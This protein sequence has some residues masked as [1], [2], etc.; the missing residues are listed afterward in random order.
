[1]PAVIPEDPP[2]LG[3]CLLT[4]PE[5]LSFLNNK[6]KRVFVHEERVTEMCAQWVNIICFLEPDGVF[7]AASSQFLWLVKVYQPGNGQVQLPRIIVHRWEQFGQLVLWRTVSHIAPDKPKLI[8]CGNLREYGIVSHCLKSVNVKHVY[9]KFQRFDS[10][11]MQLKA[12][13]TFLF[14][15]I[16]ICIAIIPALEITEMFCSSSQ[17][18]SNSDILG[19]DLVWRP[20]SLDEPRVRRT[21]HTKG[22]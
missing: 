19:V 13:H 7:L 3:R 11:A 22:R 6:S 9:I 20:R 10:Q 4:S 16:W 1:V 18:R 15:E 17:W 14:G 12:W 2:E 5:M 8:V 21:K